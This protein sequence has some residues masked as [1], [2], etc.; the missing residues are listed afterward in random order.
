MQLSKRTLSRTYV[1]IFIQKL[2]GI[3]RSQDRP[4][5][6][7]SLLHTDTYRVHCVYN[8]G[9]IWEQIC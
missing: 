5:D 2:K 4:T 9:T 6:R 8:S 7:L 3:N 1:N